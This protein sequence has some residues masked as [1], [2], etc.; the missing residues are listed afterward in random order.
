MLTS[1]ASAHALLRY[2]EVLG[3]AS[4][5]DDVEMP[6]IDAGGCTYHE[7]LRI[8]PNTRLRTVR[9]ADDE[10]EDGATSFVQDLARRRDAILTVIGLPDPSTHLLLGW[11]DH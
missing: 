7:H 3:L 2:A 11:D 5:T 8:K 1:T 10:L 9:A 4:F 6:T